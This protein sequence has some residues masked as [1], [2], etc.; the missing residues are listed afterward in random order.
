[1]S[2]FGIKCTIDEL[3]PTTDASTSLAIGSY[4]LRLGEQWYGRNEELATALN[5]SRDWA[6]EFSKN[7]RNL[8]S[9]L[10]GLSADR[11]ATGYISAQYKDGPTDDLRESLSAREFSKHVLAPDGDEGFDDGTHILVFAR[12][13][14]MRLVGMRFDGHNVFDISDVVV[15]ANEFTEKL[16][17]FTRWFDSIT[18]SQLQTSLP[19]TLE[20]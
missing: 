7:A 8:F 13:D 14:G 1:M 11:L 2:N 4:Q 9:E 15:P 3:H 19:A 16:I 18:R 6:E 17:A 10:A 5:V 12:D 20:S